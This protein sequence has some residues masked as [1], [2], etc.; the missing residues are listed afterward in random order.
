MKWEHP[1]QRFAQQLG[2]DSWMSLA[3]NKER[4][5]SHQAAFAMSQKPV[6]KLQHHHYHHQNDHQCHHDHPISTAP[7]TTPKMRKSTNILL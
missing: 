4:W 1:L 2:S 5:L 3:D 6:Q 7:Q